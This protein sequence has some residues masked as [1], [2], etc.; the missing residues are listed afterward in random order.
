M[1]YPYHPLF[2]QDIEVCG[3]AGGL[4]DIV[5]L[6]MP[7]TTRRG[8]PAWMLDEVV[9]A[10]VR[11]EEPRIECGALQR[12]AQLLDRQLKRGGTER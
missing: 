11:S 12:L 7:D 3:A 8:V 5:F 2:W 9:C 10:R 1:L 4:R 6:R